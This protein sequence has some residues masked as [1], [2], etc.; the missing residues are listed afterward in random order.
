MSTHASTV[1][2][3]G[4]VGF[5]YSEEMTK[6]EDY[7]GSHP[8]RPERVREILKHLKE[9]K[10]LDN[11]EYIECTKATEE[12]L[13]LVHTWKVVEKVFKTENIKEGKNTQWF[14]DDNYE[15]KY[16][17]DAALLAAG[18]TIAGLRAI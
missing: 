15:C 1:A 16:T 18:G 13:E 2:E 12:Q 9:K 14:D 4:S 17:K 6:H 11:V 3:G 8:E 5:V 7:S 10:L